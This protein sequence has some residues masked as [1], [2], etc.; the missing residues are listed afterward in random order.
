MY[1]PSRYQGSDTE[2]EEIIGRFP[3]A[4]LLTAGAGG[5]LK[6]SH[7]PLVLEKRTAEQWVLIG[8]L[9][10]AN[11]HWKTLEG[12]ESTAIFHGPH[13]YITPLWYEQCDVPTWNYVTAHL[14][15][16]V[17]LLESEEATLGALRKLSAKTEGQD[18]WKFEVPHDLA[19]P[20]VL[21]KSIVGFELAVSRRE[22]KLK[23]SQNK[24]ST[25]FQ[26]V[27]RG[28]SARSDEQ[29]LGVLAWM[30]RFAIRNR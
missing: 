8:H 9:A 25:D 13:A 10:R 17:A 19:A 18:G 21:M 11:D 3:F 14:S 24:G 7:V 2:I 29:S 26:G 6:I 22:A 28:L 30:Q 15:G 12:H 5:G 27:L 1:N 4:T 20:G 23:L 16:S